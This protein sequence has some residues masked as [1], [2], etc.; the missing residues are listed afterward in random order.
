MGNKKVLNPRCSRVFA[1]MRNDPNFTTVQLSDY[2]GAVYERLDENRTCEG[3]IGL[4]AASNLVCEDDGH[5]ITWA[6]QQA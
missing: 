6:I 2:F 1:E 4:Y 3:T 5:A